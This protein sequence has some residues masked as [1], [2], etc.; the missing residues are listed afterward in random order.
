M[1]D[2]K[3]LFNFCGIFC[4]LKI[5]VAVYLTTRTVM[6]SGTFKFGKDLEGGGSGV[7]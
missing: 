7:I 5:W 4:S 1:N 3:W 6:D 2:N